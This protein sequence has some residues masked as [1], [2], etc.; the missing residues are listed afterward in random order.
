MTQTLAGTKPDVDFTDG[1]F[2]ADGGAREAFRWMRANQLPGLSCRIRLVR[3]S[4]LGYD[5]G[6]DQDAP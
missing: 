2:Y 1:T 4:S 5:R 6:P 3:Q